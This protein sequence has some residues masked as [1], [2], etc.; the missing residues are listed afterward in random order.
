MT[1]LRTLYP[2]IEPFDAGMLRVSDLHEIYY[3][4]SGAQSGKPVVVCHGGPGGG[5]TPSMR[6]YF[7]PEHYKIVLFD[8]RGCGKSRPHASLEDNTTWS[9]VSDM[10]ALRAHLGINHW[11]VF[12]GSWGST[13]ALAYAQSHP[14]QVSEL[15]LRGIFALRRSELEWFYQEGASWIFPEAWQDYLAP[16]PENERN[17]LIDAY[18]KRLTGENENERI[19]AAKAW[20]LWE[21][22][23]V[24]LLPSEERMQTF[25]SDAFAL[26]FA[27]IECHYFQ[28]GGFFERDDQLIANLNRIRHIPGVIVQGRYDIVTPMKTAWEVSQQ[29]PEAEFNI[30]ADAGHAASEPGII[31]AL[32]RATDNFARR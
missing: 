15:V 32:V 14:D 25:S 5:S 7:N 24:S 30:V 21:G 17:D 3:E 12:G 19:R 23:A 2:P 1:E 4:V 28:H 16:I 26:A 10:E 29:W 13:L 8:Q 27:R 6:R 31:D 18:Y 11:Q 22:G 9:L 20:S